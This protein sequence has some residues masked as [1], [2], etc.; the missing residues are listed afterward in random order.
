MAQSVVAGDNF[1]KPIPMSYLLDIITSSAS[2]AWLLPTV[3]AFGT[4]PVVF[5]QAQL[6]LRPNLVS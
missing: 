2:S 1:G 3:R 6:P 5:S 4:E